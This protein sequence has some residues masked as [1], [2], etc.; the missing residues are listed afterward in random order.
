VQGYVATRSASGTKTDTPIIQTPQSISVVTRDQI[1]AQGAKTVSQALNYTS[2]VFAEPR[3]SVNGLFEFPNIR[4]FN[5]PSFLYQDGMQLLGASAGLQVE[6]YGL[7]RIE[8]IKGPASVLYGQGSPSGIV[9]LVTKRPTDSRFN[10]VQILGGDYNRK[11]IAVDTGGPIDEKGEVLYRFTGLARESGTQVDFTKDN[12]YY[13]APALTWRPTANTTWTVLFNYQKADS[14]FF[15]FL[16]AAGTFRPNPNGQIS[17]SFYAGDPNF[18]RSTIENTSVTS[19]FEHRFNEVVTF[20]SNYRHGELSVNQDVLTTGLLAPNNQRTLARSTFRNHDEFTTDTAD[21]QLEV[22]LN[23]FGFQHTIL[24]GFD[25]QNSYEDH[26]N[27]SGAAPSIDLFAP[28][29]YQPIAAPTL[30]TLNTNQTIEQTGAYVQHQGKLGGWNTVLGVRRDEVTSNT[31][32]LLNRTTTATSDE[33]ST[34]KAGL[35]YLFDIGLAPYASYS[36]SF[37][38]TAGTDRFGSAFKPTTGQQTEVGLKYQPKDFTGLFTFAAFDLVRQ[39]VSTPDP[40]A[41][42]LFAVQTGEVRSR[43]LEFEGKVSLTRSL[44]VIGSYTYL[45]AVVT[46]SNTIDLNKIPIG[47]PHNFGGLWGDYTIRGGQLSGLGFA[48]GVRY[49]GETFADTLNT[50]AVPAYTLYDAAIHY[51]FGELNP[52]LKGLRMQI[53]ATNLFDKTYVASCLAATNCFYGLRRSV[54]GTLAYRW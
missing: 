37:A 52:R 27:W 10:E 17:T 43:G 8:V 34:K 6:P 16:P 20:R 50:I 49:V 1:E 41:P 39:N 38:P 4:G 33:A 44:D 53:N 12:R 48:G 32:N 31:Y 14:G 21:N 18:N 13:V 25:Y 11:Q 40:A 15:N 51:E 28:A 22:K 30:N 54:I 23:T 47:V 7:E 29:Y 3:G 46:K 19:L 42:T 36:E 5:L 35:L 26:K 9:N 2:G 24:G 45:N